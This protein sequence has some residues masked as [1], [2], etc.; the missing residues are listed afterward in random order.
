[1][2]SKDSNYKGIQNFRR[3]NSN[4]FLSLLGQNMFSTT[5]IDNAIIYI[6]NYY[7]SFEIVQCG[8][9]DHYAQEI[10]LH[11][12]YRLA[13]TCSCTHSRLYNTFN[14]ALLQFLLSKED[15]SRIDN[16]KN[17]NAQLY[18]LWNNLN[19]KLNLACLFKTF[20]SSYKYGVSNWTTKDMLVYSQNLKFYSEFNKFTKEPKIKE[21]FLNNKYVYRK[22]IRTQRYFGKL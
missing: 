7:L 14:V 4:N 6:S 20:K 8:I 19:F 1:M 12:F 5:A 13:K 16:I 11:D 2:D 9:S 18:E 21:Y 15:Q 10:V 22:V 3:Y 17:V